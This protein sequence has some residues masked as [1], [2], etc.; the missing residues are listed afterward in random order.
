ML[1]I[2]SHHII[3][4][5]VEIQLAVSTPDGNHFNYPCFYKSVLILVAYTL[6]GQVGNAIFILL[7]GYFTCN[8]EKKIDLIK[9]S[10]KLLTQLAFASILLL[11]GSQIVHILMP[12]E[13]IYLEGPRIF[14][15]L[16]WYAGYYFVVIVIAGLFL[17]Q[18]LAKLD[19]KRYLTFL[20]VLFGLI[21]FSWSGG[22]L[23]GV[24]GN[25]RTVALGIFLYAFGGF[26]KK[27]K[28][29]EKWKTGWFILVILFIYAVYFLSYYNEL[30]LKIED[31][32]MKDAGFEQFLPW[33]SNYS[34]VVIAM[35]AAVF[36]L[37][38]RLPE[39]RSK[40]INFLAS[41]TLMIYLLHDN[42]FFYS[43]WNLQ[44]W[45]VMLRQ[46]KVAFFTAF[47]G[48]SLG[49]F[50]IGLLAYIAYFGVCRLCKRIYDRA[51]IGNC[52]DTDGL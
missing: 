46:D 41:A 42:D 44:D 10:K 1:G 19:E 45:I 39:F 30:E 31:Y 2:I 7:S 33:Q 48:W 14:N 28:P 34:I 32:Y 38:R 47:W 9:V 21:Q 43:L 49:V 4:H 51:V 16:S 5:S 22:V 8:D 11:L 23:E 27:Y 18:W 3:V 12:D 17:N 13:Y 37:F 15:N 20:A 26:L 36:E 24:I 25:G 6:L 29:F 52:K 50:A 40:T 35:A